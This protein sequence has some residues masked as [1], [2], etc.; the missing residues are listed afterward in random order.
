MR[1]D[2]CD[3]GLFELGHTAQVGAA[4][5]IG[6]EEA[7]DDEQPEVAGVDEDDASETGD[8]HLGDGPGSGGHRSTGE[9][10]DDREKEAAG[11]AGAEDDADLGVGDADVS[12]VD[13]RKNGHHPPCGVAGEASGVEEVGVEGGPAGDGGH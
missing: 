4:R 11:E 12:E 3:P 5:G 10:D 13:D 1:D 6:A 9:H 8:E 2:R 7:A